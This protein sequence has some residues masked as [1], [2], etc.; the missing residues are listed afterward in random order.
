VRIRA[1]LRGWLWMIGHFGLRR[2]FW[3]W[4]EGSKRGWMTKEQSETFLA[5]LEVGEAVME[6]LRKLHATSDKG[7]SATSDKGNSAQ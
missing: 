4:R 3:Y 1:S 2:A 7:N 5:T 6:H